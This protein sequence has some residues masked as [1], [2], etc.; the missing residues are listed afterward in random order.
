MGQA[1]WEA[2]VEGEGEELESEEQVLPPLMVERVELD[3]T[4]EEEGLC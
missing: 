3:L 2:V 4:S 1:P